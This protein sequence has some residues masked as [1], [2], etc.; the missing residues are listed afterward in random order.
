LWIV[1]RDTALSAQLLTRAAAVVGCASR[2]T[3]CAIAV[4][5][6]VTIAVAGKVTITVTGKI[7]I[8]VAWE[9]PVPVAHL[10][11]VARAASKITITGA[12]RAARVRCIELVKVA[13]TARNEQKREE[14]TGREYRLARHQNPPDNMTLWGPTC[15]SIGRFLLLSR[16]KSTTLVTTP[17]T[18]TPRLMLAK[19]CISFPASMSL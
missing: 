2:G 12:G 9:V 8:T 4:A 19:S 14:N 6:E 3:A 7:A 1:V 11:A 17:A 16:T 10:I 13:E 5:G 15:T 18:P